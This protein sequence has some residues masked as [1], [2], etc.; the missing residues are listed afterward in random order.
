M[1]GFYPGQNLQKITWG[2]NKK[3]WFSC[4]ILELRNKNLE[5]HVLAICISNHLPSNS[6]CEVRLRIS[7]KVKNWV[8]IWPLVSQSQPFLTHWNPPFWSPRH[9]ALPPKPSSA[10]APVGYW[11]IPD[12]HAPLAF[13][14]NRRSGDLKRVPHPCRPWGLKEPRVLSRLRITLPEQPIQT[15]SEGCEGECVYS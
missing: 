15:S 13:W 9:P 4:P 2:A 1:V 3:N 8:G 5:R 10:S 7:T 12:R 6:Q 11:C 14:L